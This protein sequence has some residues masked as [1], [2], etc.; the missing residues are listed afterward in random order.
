VN[1]KIL[2]VEDSST[3][4]AVIKVY[5]VGRQLEFIEAD[6]GEAGFQLAR[7][8]LPKVIIAD[9]KM[10]GMDGFTF[11]RRVRGDPRLRATPLILLTGVKGEEIK[12]E[13]MLA[14]ASHFMNKPIDGA[15]LAE[16]IVACLDLKK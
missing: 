5:L 9:L 16:L 1:A 13:A 2:I 7:Q 11:C 12:Q 8:H 4:R 3:T 15:A 10:P 6:D 14:G